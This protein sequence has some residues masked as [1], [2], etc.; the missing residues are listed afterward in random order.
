MA[1]DGMAKSSTS[2]PKRATILSACSSATSTERT[3]YGEASSAS[4]DS[5]PSRVKIPRSRSTAIRRDGSRR[6]R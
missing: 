1:S 5:A 2:A 3:A 6:W 4:T